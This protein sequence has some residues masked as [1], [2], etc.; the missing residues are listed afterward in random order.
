[1]VKRSIGIILFPGQF[2][3]GSE[4]EC[5]S[6]EYQSCFIASKSVEYMGATHRFIDLDYHHAWVGGRI[7]VLLRETKSDMRTNTKFNLLF[8]QAIR[9]PCLLYKWFNLLFGY[10]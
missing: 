3:C 4:F 9:L 8:I 5:F 2:V 6:F 1:M 10:I 7:S